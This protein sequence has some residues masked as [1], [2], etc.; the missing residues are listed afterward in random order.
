VSVIYRRLLGRGAHRPDQIAERQKNAARWQSPGLFY[1]YIVDNSES[2]ESAVMSIN[3]IID[4]SQA[5]P[6]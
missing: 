1:D 3:R 4:G 6:A 5:T 2:L